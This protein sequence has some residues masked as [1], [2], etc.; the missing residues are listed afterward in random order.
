MRSPSMVFFL[1]TKNAKTG[2]VVHP[3]A[4]ESGRAALV[5]AAEVPFNLPDGWAWTRL[6]EI[7]SWKA[8]ATPSRK[9]P[10]YYIG[11][12]IPWLK[13]GDLDDGIVSE[14]P[15]SITAKAVSETSVRLN[16]AGSVLMAMYGATIG[17]VGLLSIAA[18]TNQACC[19]CI[20]SNETYNKYL[21][22][23]L[24]ARRD[25]FKACQVTA[26]G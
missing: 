5:A 26:P 15:E 10:N 24:I 8:G 25:H 2:R 23:Y 11:G 19:A 18:T 21:F 13:T 3:H 12:D 20:V 17:K 7:G 9:N 4:A 14:I 16:P 1:A 6:G 22:Y